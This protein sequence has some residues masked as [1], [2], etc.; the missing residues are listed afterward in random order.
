MELMEILDEHLIR[1]SLEAFN[2]CDAITKMCELL[3]ANGY[4][5]DVD[6]FR[7]DVLKR[8]EMGETGIGNYIAIPHGQSDQVLK[9]TLCICKLKHA[10]EWETLDGRG[11]KVI[12]LFAVQ[13]DVDFA[14]THLMLLARVARKLAKEEVV[15]ALLHAQSSADVIDCFK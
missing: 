10:I 2:K 9:T 3:K 5:H 6:S 15:K 1:T 7:D 14:K 11:V 4:I 12:L 13:N 8:E